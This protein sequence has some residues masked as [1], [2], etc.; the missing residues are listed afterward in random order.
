MQMSTWKTLPWIC[1]LAQVRCFEN[2]LRFF[3]IAEAELW[4]FIGIWSRQVCG[5]GR[6]QVV[7]FGCRSLFG[8]ELLAATLSEHTWLK[9]LGLP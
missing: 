4:I 9:G 5:Q 1:C 6:G 7:N 8:G 3:F 2:D